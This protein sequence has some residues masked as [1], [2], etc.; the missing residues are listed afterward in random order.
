[1]SKETFKLFV[2]SHPEL[3]NA[4]ASGEGSWQQYY[5]KYE[6]YGENHSVWNQVGTAFT[7]APLEKTSKE[8][9]TSA[10]DTTLQDVFQMIKGLDLETVQKG[11]NGLQKA[12]GLVQDL[13]IGSKHASTR[14]TSSYEPRP[15]HK[16]YE[17]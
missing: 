14:Q 13:G 3:A 7:T 2:R 17:D 8:A 6:M 10:K 1:M 12:L 16:Y 5:E 4:V 15:I 9:K 11:V